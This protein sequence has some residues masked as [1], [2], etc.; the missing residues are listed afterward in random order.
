[1]LKK[2]DRKTALRTSWSNLETLKKKISCK[3]KLEGKKCKN[4]LMGN[5]AIKNK[6]EWYL[7]S[8]GKTI[9]FRQHSIL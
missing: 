7:K 6:L 4:I 2:H 5:S 8:S 9:K 3:K 1:M